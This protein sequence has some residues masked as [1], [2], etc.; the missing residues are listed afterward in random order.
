MLATG[1]KPVQFIGA[2]DGPH[3]LPERLDLP[4]PDVLG[5]VPMGTC[6]LD[7]PAP[8]G[9]AHSI[10][11]GQQRPLAGM[12]RFDCISFDLDGEVVRKRAD[13]GRFTLAVTRDPLVELVVFNDSLIRQH[14]PATRFDGTAHGVGGKKREEV[15]AAP[16]VARSARLGDEALDR[17]DGEVEAGGHGATSTT[18]PNGSLRLFRSRSRS[19]NSLIG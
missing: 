11:G 18:S 10:P 8:Y 9:M 17:T 12:G 2:G 7:V 16:K 4:A 13:S 15:Q 1:E 6:G 19:R 3:H 5:A 14:E